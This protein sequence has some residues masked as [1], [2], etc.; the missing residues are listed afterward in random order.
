LT[1][2]NGRYF[3]V[4]VFLF[5]TRFNAL[6]DHYYLGLIFFLLLTYA[7]LYFFVCYIA[8]TFYQPLHG[9][10]RQH[11][12]TAFSLL[13]LLG[14]MP[15]PASFFSWI[16]TATTYTISLLLLLLYI[17]QLHRIFGTPRRRT[18][19]DL[20]LLAVLII[21]MG[22]ANEVT[23]LFPF[24]LFSA[25]AA[26]RFWGL[27]RRERILFFV[28]LLHLTALFLALWL[29]GNEKRSGG[30]L[31]RQ[32]FL[33]SAL[34]ALYQ[35]FQLLYYIFSKPFFWVAL[36]LV[37]Y[38]GRYLG[39]GVRKAFSDKRTSLAVELLAL[40][41]FL[42]LFCF[43]IRQLAGIVL[44]LR[45]RNI[46]ICITAPALL[47][48]ALA[49]TRRLEIPRD[50][51]QMPG[52]RTVLAAGALLLLLFNPFTFDLLSTVVN[53]PAHDA[54]LKKQVETIQKT[55]TAGS[56]KAELA[57]YR[58]ELDK[59]LKQMYGKK[60]AAF[61]QVE[62]P[63]PPPFLYFV[64]DAGSRSTRPFY[65]EYYGIDTLEVGGVPQARFGLWH[66]TDLPP[67]GAEQNKNGMDY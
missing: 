20:A 41:G 58:D 62:F 24:F 29:P 44:P 26:Y 37:L 28:F 27:K 25:L 33:Y 13:I 18:G 49:N 5:F 3:S 39:D 47:L 61:I 9:K 48:I 15:E 19:G 6:L 36:C 34:G 53:A 55:R 1:H 21:T 38:S 50:I 7:T 14:C 66:I 23:L 60:A 46:L 4:P 2:E 57:G 10:Y 31:P 11:Q 63:S 42:F 12:I 67:A 54:V 52:M 35:V 51:V 17:I 43:V 45:T 59:Q 8:R 65:A 30:Y 64:D 32:P 22:G 56:K 40:L 16:S